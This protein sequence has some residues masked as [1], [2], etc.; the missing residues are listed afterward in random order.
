METY[1]SNMTA[2]DGTKEKL[3]ED[4]KTL[5]GDAEALVK[6]AGGQLAEKSKG[7][8]VAALERVKASCRAMQDH[9]ITGAKSA[10][11]VIREHPYQSVGIAFGI[12]LLIGV[13]CSRD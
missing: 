8:L 13:L 11:R 12:G 7:E 6:A 4:L 5:A 2:V 3:V 1:F 10:D 9:T